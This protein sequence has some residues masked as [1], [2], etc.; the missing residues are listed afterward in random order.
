VK[1][2]GGGKTPGSA[3]SRTDSAGTFEKQIRG[4]TNRSVVMRGHDHSGQ[5]KSRFVDSSILDSVQVDDVRGNLFDEGGQLPA[6]LRFHSSLCLTDFR[7][8]IRARPKFA[9]TLAEGHVRFMPRLGEAWQQGEEVC[10]HSA[11]RC[12][13][14]INVENSHR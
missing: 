2:G 6:D 9:V 4:G 1:E 12:Q 3:N 13:N 11:A 8:V 7:D 10:L 5:I 14:V